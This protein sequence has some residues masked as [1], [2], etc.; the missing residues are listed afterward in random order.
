MFFRVFTNLAERAFAVPRAGRQPG[1][2]RVEA[3]GNLRCTVGVECCFGGADGERATAPYSGALLGD[4]EVGVGP[5]R[6][7]RVATAPGL[8][9]GPAQKAAAARESAWKAK[10]PLTTA[11]FTRDGGFIS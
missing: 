10:V 7:C 9:E 3:G 8:Q 2:C 5:A 4:G 6:N 11:V 1:P